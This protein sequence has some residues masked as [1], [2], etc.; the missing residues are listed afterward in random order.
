MNLF[1]RLKN[2]L[3]KTLGLAPSRPA[4]RRKKS[5][6]K[7]KIVKKSVKKVARVLPKI[8]TPPVKVKVKK[9]KPVLKPVVVKK[10]VSLKKTQAPAK[11]KE[12][13]AAKPPKEILIGH[14]SHYFPHVNA[15]AF[16]IKKGTL[17]KGDRIHFKGHTTDFI[18]VIDSIQINRKPIELAQVGDDI[19][20]EVKDRVRE[21]DEVYKIMA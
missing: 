9:A 21:Q 13:P 10:A 8:K 4:R 6:P 15:A 17:Q 2:K 1:K 19:G 14:V 12:K 7:K 11:F 20:I 16:K 18:Q 5:A 3:L